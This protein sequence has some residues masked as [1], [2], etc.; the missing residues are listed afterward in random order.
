MQ[1]V[2]YC[3]CVSS[4]FYVSLHSS[5]LANPSCSVKITT[6]SHDFHRTHNSFQGFS[7][8]RLLWRWV[9]WMCF[10]EEWQELA[11]YSTQTSVFEWDHLNTDFFWERNVKK[12]QSSS[13]SVNSMEF[14]NRSNKSC[15]IIFAPFRWQGEYSVVGNSMALVL[16]TQ[17]CLQVALYWMYQDDTSPKNSIF[18]Q[19][20]WNIFKIWSFAYGPQPLFCTCDLM[21]WGGRGKLIHYQLKKWNFLHVLVLE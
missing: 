1:P 20:L 5:H 16:L 11:H 3:C 21:D 4:S 6:N 15:L 13:D 7:L 18:I 9:L 8:Q 12:L 17:I 14:A 19:Y 10:T 2:A